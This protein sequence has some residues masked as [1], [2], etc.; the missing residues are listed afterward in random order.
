MPGIR[1]PILPALSHLILTAKIQSHVTQ[2]NPLYRWR[3]N[4]ESWQ[5]VQDD[6]TG[7]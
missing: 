2:A 4:S 1:L 6:R 7:L 5:D 3:N